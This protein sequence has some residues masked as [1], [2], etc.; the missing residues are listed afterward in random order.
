MSRLGE[1]LGSRGAGAE[2]ESMLVGGFEILDRAASTTPAVR[3]DS[4]QRIIRYYD[5]V[6][7]PAAS[8]PWRARL[9]TEAGAGR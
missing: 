4:I 5:R 8:I 1:C 3:R 9:E 7:R 2:A 6:G